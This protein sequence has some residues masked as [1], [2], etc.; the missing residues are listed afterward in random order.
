MDVTPQVGSNDEPWNTNRRIV[1]NLEMFMN[2]TKRQH[3]SL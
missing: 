2:P 3:R 1:I